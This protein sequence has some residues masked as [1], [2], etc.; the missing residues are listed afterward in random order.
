MRRLGRLHG[1]ADGEAD[2]IVPSHVQQRPCSLLVAG[3]AAILTSTATTQP[4][5]TAWTTPGTPADGATV[6][7]SALRTTAD[8]SAIPAAVAREAP[9]CATIAVA[10]SSAAPPRRPT[11]ELRA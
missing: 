7:S 5:A 9:A 3:T 2:G 1:G 6:A 8:A 4:S 10:T 11:S